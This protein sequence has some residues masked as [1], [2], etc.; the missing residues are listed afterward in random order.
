MKQKVLKAVRAAA[1]CALLLFTVL[2]AK[3][4]F[5]RKEGMERRVPFLKEKANTDV[6]FLGTSHVIDGIYPMELWNDYGITS[7]NL[8]DSQSTMATAYWVL[9]EAL[10]YTDPKVVVLDASRLRL[11]IKT[12]QKYEMVQTAFDGFPLSETKLLAGRDLLDDPMVDQLV[13]E[14]KVTAEDRAKR[15]LSTFL[16][17]LIWYHSRWKS[18]EE[19]DFQPELNIRKGAQYLCAVAEPAKTEE[20]PETDVYQ[21]E[22]AGYVYLRK[23]IDEC[24]ARG[25]E[26]VLTYLPFPADTIQQK[27]ANT[28]A[29]VAE[30]KGI[31]YLN[32]LR[33]DVVNYETDCYDSVSHLNPSGAKK[34]TDYLGKYLTE[35]LGVPD[36]RGEAEYAHWDEDFKTYE[37]YKDDVLRGTDDLFTYLMLLYGEGY[38]AVIE[39]GKGDFLTRE[40]MLELFSNLGFDTAEIS[41]NSD[42]FIL[43]GGRAAL[44]DDAADADGCYETGA[45]VFEIVHDGEKCLR[46]LDGKLITDQAELDASKRYMR[47]TVYRPGSGEKTDEVVF[48]YSVKEKKSTAARRA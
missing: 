9:M 48:L 13:E 26:I 34:V 10:E 45:G 30:E 12:S 20:V 25:I 5:E 43:N 28:A 35:N 41:E 6:L 4:L 47:F 33:M 44:L 36:H 14:G 7:Y 18:L 22:Q 21:T 40:L 8:A 17:N 38:E 19:E 24:R 11:R 42:Y 29:V 23:I 16:F 3:R 1:F 37:A 31:P 27:E 15:Q 32:F 46:Y 39:T 2:F